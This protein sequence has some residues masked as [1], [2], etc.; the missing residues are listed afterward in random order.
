MP[1]LPLLKLELTPPEVSNTLSALT[2]HAEEL[3]EKSLKPW[4][5]SSE[6]ELYESQLTETLNVINKLK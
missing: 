1:H 4:L 6:K 3:R 5:S 2:K